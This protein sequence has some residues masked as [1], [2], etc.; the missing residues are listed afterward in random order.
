MRTKVFLLIFVSTALVFFSCS[1]D[2]SS[3]ANQEPVINSLSADHDVVYPSSKTKF[4]CIAIDAEEDSLGYTWIVS[5]GELLVSD[6]SVVWEAPNSTGT[7]TLTVIVS[8]SENSVSKEVVINVVDPGGNLIFV[9]VGTF[10]QGLAGTSGATPIHTVHVT[11]EYLMGK[12]EV[13]QKEWKEIMGYCDC[14]STYGYGDDYPIYNINWI[15]ALTYC[16]KRSLAEGLDPCYSVDV[17]FQPDE[18]LVDSTMTQIVWN[19][20]KCDFSKNGYRLPTETEWEYAARFNDG[21]ANPWGDEEATS[22]LCVM[23]SV[24][25]MKVGSR[26]PQGDSTLGFCDLAGNVSEMTWDWYADYTEE[27]LIDPEGPQSGTYRIL[28]GGSR[29]ISTPNACTNRGVHFALKSKGSDS[30][31]RV[32]RTR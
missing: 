31:F 22:F 24:S 2:P 13:T 19:S 3:P 9:P 4:T 25:T 10:D 14:S 30:G 23:A 26:S 15:E 20:V 17:S 1:N 18:W 21:R 16:N 5:R 12:Y 6:N 27:E 7:D 29:F 32:V 28:R 8:D 11:R